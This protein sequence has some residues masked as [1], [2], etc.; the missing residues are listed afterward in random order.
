MHK[1]DVDQVE[2]YVGAKGPA[3]TPKVWRFFLTIMGMLL[4]TTTTSTATRTY[5]KGKITE[6]CHCTANQKSNIMY[7]VLCFL[8]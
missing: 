7:F 2:H 8:P 1:E 5:Y 3:G 6:H 4:A